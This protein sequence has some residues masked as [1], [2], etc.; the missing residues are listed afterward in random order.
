MKYFKSLYIITFFAAIIFSTSC[1][2][3]LDTTS[4]LYV[5]DDAAIVD[6]KS[7]NAVLVGAY[8]L[9]S[10]NAYQGNTFRYVT[11]LS[12]D[13]LKWV[14]NTPTNRE[15]WVH[16]I[17][18]T[19]SRVSELWGGIYKTINITNHIITEVP[20]IK[21]ITY[22]QTNR[23]SDRG[24]AFFIRAFSYFDLARIWGKVPIQTNPTTSVKNVQPNVEVDTVYQQVERDLDSAIALLPL[25]FNR[26]HANQYAAKSLKARLYLYWE[27]WTKAESNATEVIN[28]T[29]DFKL[30]KPYNLFYASKNTTES[31][32]EINYTVNN[33]NSWASN[34]F[35]SNVTGGKR[36]LLPTDDL[37][38]LLKDPTK[39]GDRSAL[40][41]TIN[42][43]TYG[44][45]N[46]KIATGDD[47]AFAIR[48][49]ELYLIRAEARA[50]L[51]NISGG[52]SDLNTIRQRSNVPSINTVAD[53]I[54]LFNKI[55]DERRLEFAYESHRWFDL[56]RTKKAQSVLSI[57]DVYR[58]RFPLPK[59]EILSNPLLTQNSGY[60]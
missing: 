4:E 49:A 34:W 21:D 8:S 32:F 39:G 48:I 29:T 31:V 55:Q 19:N 54:D 56:I 35:A 60:N 9:L 58:L 53:G 50:K 24:E 3:V 45:M 51:A 37:I 11:N 18:A 59:Q 43:V 2:K 10:A 12:S 1:N 44:N 7:A 41:L 6:K 26:N 15:F 33:K 25:T 42:G 20:K 47:Q 46:F 17:F 52:L 16:D 40:L 57:S 28:N 38:A 36:E 13:N 30:V 14:G 23:N 22:T 5:S 27:N